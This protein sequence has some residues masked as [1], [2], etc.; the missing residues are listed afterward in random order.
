MTLLE[1][2]QSLLGFGL[3]GHP[4]LEHGPVLVRSL[5]KS[6]SL[7]EKHHVVDWTVAG[8]VSRLETESALV[9][10]HL[11]DCGK[12]VL[13]NRQGHIRGHFAQDFVLLVSNLAEMYGDPVINVVGTGPL[14]MSV[15]VHQVQIGFV[16]IHRFV[17][18]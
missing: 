4:F 14:N 9:S 10:R 2:N 3:S 5:V 13:A 15:D 1:I 8:G 17:G 6:G 16:W 7:E 18:N 11:A 12:Q